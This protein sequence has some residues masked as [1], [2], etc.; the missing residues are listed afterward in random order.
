MHG[1]AG[2]EQQADLELSKMKSEIAYNVAE[3]DDD[4]VI[5]AAVWTEIYCSK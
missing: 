4:D 1:D 2:H 3:R 5:T